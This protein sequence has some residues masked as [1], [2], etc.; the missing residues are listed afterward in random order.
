MTAAAAQGEL[1]PSNVSF[2]QRSAHEHTLH[3]QLFASSALVMN[4]FKVTQGISILYIY[5]LGSFHF[6]FSVMSLTIIY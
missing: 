4:K 2:V 6:G 5:Y 1:Q 3:I